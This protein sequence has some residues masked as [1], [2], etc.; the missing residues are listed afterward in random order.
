VSVTRAALRTAL[1][2]TV[3]VSNTFCLGATLLLKC[4]VSG[5]YTT[6]AEQVPFQE[7]VQV[8]VD[9]VPVLTVELSGDNV[10]AFF[11]STP[12]VS[13]K[14]GRETFFSDLST[15]D[16]WELTSES[17]GG[18]PS[19]ASIKHQIRIDRRT[20]ALLFRG[21]YTRSEHPE[22]PV[23]LEATGDCERASNQRRF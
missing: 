2:A 22:R 10:N 1:C 8:E 16:V 15:A 4:Q 12:R 9:R 13:H 18:V 20:G 23:F 6:A 17:M 7:I 3:L 14:D 11:S 21:Q 19:Q 5:R